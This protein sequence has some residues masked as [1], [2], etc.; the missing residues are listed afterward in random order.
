MKNSIVFFLF[1]ITSFVNAQKTDKYIKEKDV[2]RIIQTLAA[3]DMNGR[4]AMDEKS[5]F[6]AAAFIEK[7]FKSIGLSPLSGATGFLQEFTKDKMVAG[8]EVVIDNEKIADD[9]VI[10]ATEKMQANITGG[11]AI[12]NISVDN[13]VQN[14]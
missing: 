3:D 8:G 11:L 4:S 12:K 7:E 6:K 9:H 13:S 1:A 10:I 5:I 14:K 2:T